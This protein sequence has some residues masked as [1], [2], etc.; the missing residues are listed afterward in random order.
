MDDR[1]ALL[2]GLNYKYSNNNAAKL[3]GCINDANNIKKLLINELNFKEENIRLVTDDTNIDGTKNNILKMFDWLVD[4]SNNGV[5]YLWLSFAGHG[6]QRFDFG[7]DETDNY[8]ECIIPLDYFKD[9]SIIRDDEIV[10]RLIERLNPNTN[11]ISVF[12]CCHS[13]TILDLP[14][15]FERGNLLFR[16]N[17]VLQ[18]RNLVDKKLANVI[19]FSGCKDYEKSEETYNY[20]NGKFEITGAMTTGVIN[21][22]KNNNYEIKCIDLYNLLNEYTKT[23]NHNQRPQISS[24]IKID[25]STNFIKKGKNRYF[26]I[27]EGEEEEE[28]DKL[29]KSIYFNQEV[30]TT[31]FLGDLILLAVNKKYDNSINYKYIR[32]NQQK[33]NYIEKDLETLTIWFENP[34]KNESPFINNQ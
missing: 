27:N 24:T 32:F 29:Y 26:F 33:K 5:K 1:Y 7:G 17:N 10:S 2:I 18:N 19:M 9:R 12:D 25:N 6:I 28:E 34:E 3:D 16:D 22:L 13:G 31:Q 21:I 15:S 11:L 4:L 23:N 14:Y 30:N 20:I 8:D